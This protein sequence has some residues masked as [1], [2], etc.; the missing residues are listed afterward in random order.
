[1]EQGVCIE[2]PREERRSEE[3]RGSIRGEGGVSWFIVGDKEGTAHGAT[4]W[5]NLDLRN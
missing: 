3:G 5:L 4:D 2:Y 1:M